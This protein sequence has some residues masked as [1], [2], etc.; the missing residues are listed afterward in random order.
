MEFICLLNLYYELFLISS[1]LLFFRG[2]GLVELEA[3]LFSRYFHKLI[4]IWQEKDYS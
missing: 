4:L 3:S 1:D 2:G